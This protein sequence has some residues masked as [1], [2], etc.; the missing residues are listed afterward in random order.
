MVYSPGTAASIYVLGLRRDGRWVILHGGD[1]KL[2]ALETLHRWVRS[3][4]IVSGRV[5]RADFSPIYLVNPPARAKL[6]SNEQAAIQP[7]SQTQ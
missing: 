3:G 2:A 7:G 5:T 6:G 4:A 1:D